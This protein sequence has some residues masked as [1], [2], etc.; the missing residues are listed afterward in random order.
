MIP[1]NIINIKITNVYE[2]PMDLLLNLIKKEKI[3]ICD[4]PISYMTDEFIKTMGEITYVNLESFLD[5]SIMASSLLQIK[6]KLLLPATENEIEDEDPREDL[7]SKI[8]E[9]NYFKYISNILMDYY[10]IGSIKLEKKPEDLT[11]LALEENIDYNEVS[12]V[13][14]SNS[15][16]KLLKR[17]AQKNF[18]PEYDIEQESITVEEGIIFLRKLLNQKSAFNFKSLFTAESKKI[19]IITLFLAILELSKIRIINIEQNLKEEI[20]INKNYGEN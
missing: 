16:T 10:K 19:E 11:L 20:I 18:I 7:V 5:F 6:S 13:K 17:K 9:Y 8:I 2:G 15:I 12:P 4:I 14:L 1:E 3:D